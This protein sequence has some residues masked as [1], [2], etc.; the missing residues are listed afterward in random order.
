[1]NFSMTRRRSLI[2]MAMGGTLGA[3]GLP[4]TVF[5]ATPV[6]GGTISVATIGEPP[7]LDPMMSTADL[8]GIL[9]QHIF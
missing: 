1:M 3:V 7:T 8:V 6:K 4:T 9:T 2:A 5:G